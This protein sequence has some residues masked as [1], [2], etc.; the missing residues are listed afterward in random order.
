MLHLPPKREQNIQRNCQ[1][2]TRLL[3]RKW[4][5]KRDNAFRLSTTCPTADNVDMFNKL[6]KEVKKL[7]SEDYKDN[8]NCSIRKRGVYDA[9]KSMCKIKHSKGSTNFDI[10]VNEI[11]EYFIEIST[12]DKTIPFTLPAKRPLIKFPEN[13][14]TLSCVNTSDV[15]KAWKS[16]KKK[17]S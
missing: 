15:Y 13:K 14:F 5:E 9:V 7:I 11:N 6:N 8:L 2:R 1:H 4:R 3:R 12:S 16:M 10:N 17:D